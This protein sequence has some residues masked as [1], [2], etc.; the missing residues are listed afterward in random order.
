M[1][2]MLDDTHGYDVGWHSN[3]NKMRSDWS[4]SRYFLPLNLGSNGEPFPIL[5]PLELDTAI[6]IF[7]VLLLSHIQPP[8]TAILHINLE[9]LLL[10][11]V[12]LRGHLDDSVEGD[13]NVG[14]LIDL[15]AEE[16]GRNAAENRLMREDQDRIFLPL[17]PVD[18]RLEAADDIHIRLSTGVPEGQL[19]FF[20]VLGDVW[21][22]LFDF[23]VGQFLAN[24]GIELV[25]HFQLD[26]FDFIEF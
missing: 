8:E 22:L 18:E 7:G 25:E 11:R 4:L 6:V 12:G 26:V 14:D 20:P 17:D 19:V 24:A 21:V 15:D 5:L 23:G 2:V 10:K 16:I 1:D 9:V 3:D 13:L